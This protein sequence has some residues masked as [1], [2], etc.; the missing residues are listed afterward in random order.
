MEVL[1][2]RAQINV[3]H[4][5]YRGSA[6]ALTDLIGG[7]IDFNI[8]SLPVLQSQFENPDLKILAALSPERDR[9]LSSIPTM[10][11]SGI[12][13]FNFVSW[14]A[15]VGPKGIPASVASRL[16][17]A[18]A[19][20]ARAREVAEKLRSIGFEPVGSSAKE[21]DDEQ[22]KVAQIWREIAQETGIRMGQ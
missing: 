17:V 1:K 20:G 13:N 3:V 4:V 8:Q 9:R 7:S 19:E 21:L 5:P 15:I 12:P 6:A 18:L 2:R 16:S 22:R 14:T 10:I 11:E